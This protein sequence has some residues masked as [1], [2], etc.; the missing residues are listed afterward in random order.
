MCVFWYMIIT[1]GRVASVVVVAACCAFPGGD[2][3]VVG[4]AASAPHVGTAAP[5]GPV[6]AAPRPQQVQD[7][8]PDRVRPATQNKTHI[9]VHCIWLHGL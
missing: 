4:A 1:C 9:T 6:S 2:L 7:R 8:R 5:P 3:E